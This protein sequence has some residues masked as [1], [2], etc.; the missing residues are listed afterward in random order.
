MPVHVYY[1][2]VLYFDIFYLFLFHLFLTSIL[3]SGI[4]LLL[5]AL[6]YVYI[7]L[8]FFLSARQ[9]ML[10]NSLMEIIFFH[11]F[12][13]LWHTSM[14]C[15][16]EMWCSLIPYLLKPRMNNFFQVFGALTLIYLLA[17]RT[18]DSNH[19]CSVIYSQ[20]KT[21]NLGLT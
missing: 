5:W 7:F 12:Y 20:N 9:Q 18:Y 8:F 19:F 2:E 4:S 15:F 1:Y 14:V 6:F 16:C 17:P 21:W 10:R 3:Y 11:N 13:Y